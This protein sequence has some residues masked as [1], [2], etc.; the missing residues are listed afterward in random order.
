[1]RTD[2]S[3]YVIVSLHVQP[4]A[5]RTEIV[6]L[7]GDALKVKLAAPPADG[8]ANACLTEFLADLLGVARADVRLIGGAASRRKLVR[9][10]GVSPAA[11]QKLRQLATA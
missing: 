4:N 10:A 2:A 1:M 6:G 7:Y 11:V 8:R 9:V 5:A 3:G